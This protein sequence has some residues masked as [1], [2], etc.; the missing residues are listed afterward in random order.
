MNLHLCCSHMVLSFFSNMELTLKYRMQVLQLH[1]QLCVS[2]FF[3][4]NIEMVKRQV[5]YY[6]DSDIEFERFHINSLNLCS[7]QILLV[8]IKTINALHL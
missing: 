2:W 4:S 6:V 3:D 1:K 7:A 8:Y 5:H